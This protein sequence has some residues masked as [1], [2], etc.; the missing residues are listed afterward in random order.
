MKQ[1]FAAVGV[2]TAIALAVLSVSAAATARSS[3]IPLL[4][5]GLVA[6]PNSLDLT[7]DD[8]AA[9]ITSASLET[10][11][12]LDSKG[13]LKPWL[14]TR[15]SHPSAA[16]YVYRLR[17]GVKFWDGSTLTA[18]DVVN[19]LNY[20][21]Y[22]GAITQY[23]YKSVKSISAIG[24]YSV[25]IVLRHP[26]ASWA[27][28]PAEYVSEIF[29]RH[30]Q[31]A[32]KAT[33][34][35]PGTLVMG[36]GPYETTSFDPT[37]GAE[38]SPNPHY[39][40]R[41]PNIRHIS[42]KFFSNETSAAL[43]L[44]AGAVDLVPLVGDPTAFRATSGG[45]QIVSSPSCSEGFFSMNTSA[46]P[47][48]DIHVRRA[49]AYA[50]NRNDFISNIGGYATPITTLIPP[51]Q[52]QVLGSKAR[53]N[54]LIRRLPQYPYDLAKARAEMAKSAYRHGFSAPLPAVQYQNYAPGS[55][56]I[57]GA[58]AKIGIK[59]NV[60]VEPIGQWSSDISGAPAKRPAV[61]IGGSGCNSP[62]PSFYPSTYLGSQGI[63]QGGY[64]LAS[65]GPPAVDTLIAKAAASERRSKRLALYGQLLKRL[66]TDLPYIP[67]YVKDGNLGISSRFSW[68]SYTSEWYNNAAWPTEITQKG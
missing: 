14:A 5:V 20:E 27:Y 22:P 65:Y 7:K 42:Y 43:A 59:L 35:H 46:P 63:V 39:W 54:A 15:V 49:V 41:K 23:A 26:D 28:V 68:P 31:L 19:S 24:R 52:L 64:N 4:R 18:A 67:L 37:S 55:Q 58:L 45:A 34:G 21:R 2:A 29:E 60:Q 1:A 30:F 9:W 25:R 13:N 16:V 12:R 56:I 6:S 8:T 10:L 17:K 57:A 33:F 62:D 51:V 48:N 50:L 61:F 47:W 44:R 36:T 53:V 40:G 38:L 32:H 11:M 66:A 3:A